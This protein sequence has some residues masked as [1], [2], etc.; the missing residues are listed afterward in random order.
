MTTTLDGLRKHKLLTKADAAKL[1]PLYSQDG[2]GY[3]AIA[4]VKFFSPYSGWRWYATE[5]DGEDIFYGYVEGFEKEFGYFSLKELS[6]V[7]V[8]GGVPAVERDKYWTPKPLSEI[9]K[10][11]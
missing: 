3:A 8:F 11:D 7:T 10:E 4:I 6:E 1:P 5:F 9:I 2:K